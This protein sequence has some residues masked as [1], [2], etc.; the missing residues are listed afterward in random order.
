MLPTE[1]IAYSAIKDR[2]RLELPGGARLVF[3]TGD[4][5]FEWYLAQVKSKWVAR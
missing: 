5:I 4:Q 1:R 2:P 3:W